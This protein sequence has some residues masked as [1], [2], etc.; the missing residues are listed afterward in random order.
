MDNPFVISEKVIPKYFCD[1]KKESAQLISLV[2]NRNN[3][4]LIAPRRIGKTALIQYCFEKTK[5]KKDYLTF[6]ID[7]LSTTNLREF[8][9]ILGK[10]IVEQIQPLG[11]KMLTSFINNV[12]SLAGKLGFDP[13]SGMPTINIQLGDITQ[14]EYTLQEIFKYLA[15]AGKPCIVAIDEFQQVAKYPERGVEALLRSHILQINNCRFIFSGSERHLLQQMFSTPARPFYNSSSLIELEAIPKREYVEFIVDMF[16][17][18]HKNIAPELAEEIYDKF[19][20]FTF[21]VQR[22]CNSIFSLTPPEGSAHRDMMTE[23]LSVILYSYDTL[24]RERLYTLSTRQK[25][26][27]FAIAAEGRVSKINSVEF[28]QSHSLS[29]ASAVQTAMKALLRM[30]IVEKSMGEV[31]IVDKF[32]SLWVKKNYC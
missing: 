32:F 6:Y 23:S 30:D 29:S 15:N 16:R 10:T 21:Y 9:F 2:E 24:F 1:R 11:K 20:G 28:I 14:P 13:I 31:Y 25:E 22:L 12:K 7:I 3:V 27:L 26:L 19:D 4:V 17:K 8:I 5:I 18:Q